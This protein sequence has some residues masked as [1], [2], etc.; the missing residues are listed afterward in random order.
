MEENPYFPGLHEDERIK[1]FIH[2]H[3]IVHLRIFLTLLI[4]VILPV[5]GAAL[6]LGQILAGTQALNTVLVVLIF[7]LMCGWLFAYIRW[8]DE[9]YDCIVITSRRIIDITQNGLVSI[10]LSETSLDLLQDV[11]GTTTG[12]IGNLMRYGYLEVQ[13][14]GRDQ[15]FMMDHVP[16]PGITAQKVISEKEAFLGRH[17][18]REVLKDLPTDPP[19]AKPEAEVGILG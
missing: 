18:V 14:A 13:T 2:K 19:A 1:L 11:R 10:S 7:Y 16:Y 9:E 8:I 12:I 17:N 5:V 6:W 15:V 3:W 4:F